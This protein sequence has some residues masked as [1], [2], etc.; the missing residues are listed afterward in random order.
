MQNLFSYPLVVDE[1]TASEKKYHLEANGEERAYLKDV[2]KVE[3]VKSFAADIRVKYNKKEHLLNVWG[4]AEAEL[5]LQSVISLENFYKTY[6]PEFSVVYDTQA[7]LKEIKEMDVDIYDEEPDIIIGG[8][9][10]LGQVAIEQVALVMDDNPRKEGEV[11]SFQSE[12]D[13]ED[14]EKLNPF[15]VLK[16]LK[17]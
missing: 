6:A 3:G 4:T 17:K 8:K 13:E 10:D 7:T 1:L 16:K 14:T 12:F 15:N 11:F 9:L 2:L 5:E